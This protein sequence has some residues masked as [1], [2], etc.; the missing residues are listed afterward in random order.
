MIFSKK[1]ID[2]YNLQRFI[3][4]QQSPMMEWVIEELS[5]GRK[6]GHWMWFIFPQITGLG[7]SHN[8]KLYA[9]TS[10]AEAKA[11]WEHSQV[12]ERL[13]QCIELVLNSNKTAFEIFGK[14]IDVMKFHSC[15]T[16]FLQ[17]DQSN[18]L[19]KQAMHQF[20]AGHL[21]Q[22]TIDLIH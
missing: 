21:D 4:A 6:Q 5:S 13:R 18:V 7:E 10:L 15:L 19:I 9:I 1:N 12:G 2:K 3:D 20:F 14:D 16:L 11:Y 8:S 22:K 17:L